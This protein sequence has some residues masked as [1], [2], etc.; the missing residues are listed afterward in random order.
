MDA[1]SLIACHE[2]DLLQRKIFLPVSGIARCRRCR[3]VLY[4]DHPNGLDRALAC[5]LGALVLLI[6]ANAYPIVGLEIQG[7]RQAASLYDTVHAL[8]QDDR[9]EVAALVGFTTMVFPAIEIATLTY[10]LLPLRLGRLAHGTVPVLHFLQSVRPWSMMEVFMLGIL[11]SLVK[12]EHIAHVH[13]GIALWAFAC[14]I[15]LLA[16]AAAAFDPEELW[17]R[18]RSQS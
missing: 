16:A 14:L 15:P 5:T 1:H 7:N 10:L 9:K 13:K 12:L 4:R 11:V 18:V 6:V 3:A 17:A 2:C 8:W